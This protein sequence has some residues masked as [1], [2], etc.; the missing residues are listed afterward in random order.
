MA[1]EE[2]ARLEADRVGGR[3]RD[4]ERP[5]EDGRGEATGQGAAQ[6]RSGGT[7]QSDWERHDDSSD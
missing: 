4:R 1:L 6:K 3:G 2:D 7:R 5:D